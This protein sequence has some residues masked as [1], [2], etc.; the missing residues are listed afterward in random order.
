MRPTN[1][2]PIG[3]LLSGG[4]DS[5]ILLAHFLDQQRVVQPF[6]IVSGLVWQSTELACAREF[7][8]AVATP[9]LRPLV[10]L[11]MPLADLYGDHWSVDGNRVPDEHSPDEAVFLPGRNALLAIKAVIWC[12]LHGIREL[13][14]APL[15]TSPFADATEDFCRALGDVLNR[16][17]ANRGNPCPVRITVPFATMNKSQVMRLGERYP[18][19]W[20][21]SCIAPRQGLHCGRC[22]KCAERREAFRVAQRADPTRYLDQGAIECS[23]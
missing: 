9:D 7:L 23:E 18:L 15:G 8:A 19:E 11:E 17:I 21:F 1:E 10:T 5:A 3:V 4:L 13:A 2:S 6:Y 20:T 12:Q 16:G 22:N 14:L